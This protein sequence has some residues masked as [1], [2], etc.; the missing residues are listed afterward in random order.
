MC[1]FFLSAVAKMPFKL[2]S[3]GP[4]ESSSIAAMGEEKLCSLHMED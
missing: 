2:R 4:Y 3:H 1:H